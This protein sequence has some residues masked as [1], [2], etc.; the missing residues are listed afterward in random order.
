MVS[1]LDPLRQNHPP[2]QLVKYLLN[3]QIIRPC[4]RPPK[5]ELLTVGLGVSFE[6]RAQLI[7]LCSKD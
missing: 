1:S 4:P 2:S 7:L 5:S 3:M 6:T